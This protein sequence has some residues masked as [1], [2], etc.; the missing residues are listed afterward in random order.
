MIPQTRSLFARQALL[1][2][3]W[4]SDVA[5]R[6]DEAGRIASI[7]T[8]ASPEG[9]ETLAG[10]VV[11]ALANLHSHAFQRA[12]AGLAETAGSGEDSFWTWRAEMYRTVGTVSPE[13][14]EA[15]AAKLYVEMLKGGFSRVAE[16]HYLHHGPG[17]TPYADP[18][19]TSLRILAAARTAGIGLTHLPVFYAHSNFGGAAPG[20]G[21]RPF[22]H[23]VDGFLS[24]LDRLAP[25]CEKA[26]ARLGLAIHSLRAATPDEMRAILSAETTGGPIHIHVAEQERE[27]EE[28]VAWSGRRPVEWLLGEMPV[29]E[30]WCA[31]HATHMTAA[32]TEGL[33]RSGAVAGLC[34]ATEANLGDGIFP[35]TAFLKAG[36]RFGIGTDSHVATDVAEELRLLEYGQR[37]RDRRRS[38]LATGPGASVGRTLHD[39]ALRGGAQ[40][41]GERVCGLTVGASADLVVLDGADPYIATASGD[42][43]LDRWLFAL[44]AK[45]V[46]DVL[47]GGRFVVREGR[48][49]ADEAV[50]A[51][52]L[53]TLRRLA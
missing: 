34:P 6:L 23:D 43:I 13:D 16:F 30:R 21:Q 8:D 12:M 9:C 19:E 2:D 32:E 20:E 36:G 42:A 35:A 39:A 40:A 44:G 4:A 14:V 33:A 49:A 37:L 1:P 29:D 38:R 10:P 50:D 15:I 45:V 11:P 28:S 46:R 25:A 18:A 7:E 24:L 53:T 27:V 17:G 22:L 26:G 48:H 47:V 52:F 3:G 5:I 51:A 31:I 41:T